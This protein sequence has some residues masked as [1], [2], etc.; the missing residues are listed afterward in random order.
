[1][2]ADRSDIGNQLSL[3]TLVVSLERVVGTILKYYIV[4]IKFLLNDWSIF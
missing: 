1:M 4:L 2:T 3:S